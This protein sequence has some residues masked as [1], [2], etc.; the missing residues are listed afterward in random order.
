MGLSVFVTSNL[1]NRAAADD[2]QKRVEKNLKGAKIDYEFNQLTNE[3]K[4]HEMQNKLNSL[5]SEESESVLST[6]SSLG[7]KLFNFLAPVAIDSI[8]VG[9]MHNKGSQWNDP[10]SYKDAYMPVGSMVAIGETFID[11]DSFAALKELQYLS[12]ALDASTNY[13]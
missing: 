12:D 4:V 8:L 13:L 7:K 10:S 2:L 11:V 6:I 1:F 5:K 9:M 3:G